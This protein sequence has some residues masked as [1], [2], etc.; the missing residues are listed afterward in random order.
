[1]VRSICSRNTD[2][3]LMQQQPLSDV[4]AA[5]PKGSANGITKHLNRIQ[6]PR[7]QSSAARASPNPHKAAS[8]QRQALS[9]KASVLVAAPQ[10][11]G[12]FGSQDVNPSNYRPNVDESGTQI[13][14]MSHTAVFTTTKIP[15]KQSPHR[16]TAGDSPEK[17]FQTAREEQT[18][19][20][21][22]DEAALYEE[23]AQTASQTDPTRQPWTSTE[24]NHAE[25][26]DG[27][28]EDTH[29]DDD[30]AIQEELNEIRSPSDESSPIRPM[31]RKNSLNFPSLPA[32]EPLTAG[33]SI[34]ARTSRTSHLDHNRTSYYN[35]PTG[36][37]SLGNHA[38]Q[39]VADDDDQDAM[40]V[41]ADQQTQASSRAES[42]AMNH[43]RTYT[44]RLQDQI[45]LLGKS[46][47]N[48][49]HQSKSIPNNPVPQ[50]T[51]APHVI[52]PEPKSPSPISKEVTQS[53]PGA[54]PEDDDDDWIQPPGTKVTE[55]ETSD[56]RPTLSK[57]HSADVMEGIRDKATVSQEDFAIQEMGI[58]GHQP[59]SAQAPPSHVIGHG[60]SAAVSTAAAMT[61]PIYDAEGPAL[62]KATTMPNPTTTSVPAAEY[63]DSPPKSPSRGFRDSP[64]KQVKNK[65]SSILK[66]SR[67]LLA[68][69]AAISA[70]GKS[71]ILSPYTLRLGYH[72]APSMDSIVSKLN[73]DGR[74]QGGQDLSPGR[75]VARRTRASVEREKEEKRREK[76]EKHVAEQMG[77]LEKAREKEREKARVFS[78][79]QERTAVMEKQVVSQKDNERF[80]PK[81]TPK[82]TRS[83]PRKAKAPE[84]IA[85]MA[86]E[87]DTEMLDVP[88]TMPPPSVPRSTGP[89]QGPRGKDI[90][91]PIKPPTQIKAKQA[92]TV[93]KVNT[94]SQHSQYHATNAAP[95]IPHDI[96]ASSSS[97]IQHQLAT[98]ASKASLQPKSS[99]QSLKSSASSTGRTKALDL[100]AKKKEQDEKEMQRRRDAKAEMERKRVAAQEEQRK[101]E[102]Q[103][104]QEADR[105]K[106]KEREQA[107]TAQTDAKKNAQRQ[108]AIEKAKQTRAPPPAVRSQPN[109]PPDYNLDED[110]NPSAASTQKTEAASCRPPSRM[111]S[112]M[113]RSQDDTS[114]P[115][116]TVLSN[117]TKAV[118]RTLAADDVEDG[119]SKRPPSRGGLS[120]QTKDA[121]RR[122]TSETTCAEQDG[123]QT[124][125]IKGAPVRPS[126]GLKKV[127]GADISSLERESADM[128][129][130][131]PKK[132]IFQNGYTNAPPS[133]TRDLFKATVTAQHAGQAK[134]GHP[135][136]M[137]QISK[138]AIPFAPSANLTSAKTPARPA[139]FNAGKSAAK[140]AQRS[141]PRFQ[142]GESIELPEI[143]TD[144][145]DEDEDDAHGMNIAAWADSPDLRRAL[146]R[147]ETMDPSQIFGPPS[148]LNMEEVFSKNKDRWHKFRARTSSANWSG[149]D[150]LTED[151]VRKDMAARDKLR[152][153]G[154]WSYD[155][156]KELL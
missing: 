141:S 111:N 137:A 7:N 50:A 104:R 127:H 31:V 48:A 75:P 23:R 90:K 110:K 123:N 138:G 136:D 86:S 140:S 117:A 114:R 145:E 62:T 9:P 154:G 126:G 11:S 132:S 57:S 27:Q 1:M 76:E 44:Q 155:M 66:S 40:D 106:Q 88:L 36:G 53:T 156:G 129:Q 51:T 74:A 80:I 33:K 60:Q 103:R 41:D 105:Q 151:D 122:R 52:R 59:E 38:W 55:G 91:R 130:D 98:K 34:G 13:T 72:A 133:V 116:N 124:S 142:N 49:N 102:Q 70:E 16:V 149:V 112:G 4:F 30:S 81:E 29:K 58:T 32:R 119:Q 131:L 69:S 139:A 84:S 6:S 120:Y 73:F 79:E 37:K 150:R 89:S 121:K 2:S 21:I 93:I 100:A 87:Q 101:Q 134:P 26:E 78:K 92:P 113:P 67:G 22:N 97:Q 115:V 14:D 107:A 61:V 3:I 108:A 94:G 64:L 39:D 135:L 118:K 144:D 17:T 82:P 18:T 99:M 12:Y 83:S 147:Q 42:V 85:P 43:T 35:R 77:K 125:S 56:T 71:S 68:S 152:R 24:Q 153:E 54:F 25:A 5:T 19:R 109:G 10:D 146:M 95:A 20:V 65:L 143:Q 63:A 148:N 47:P 8:P 15:L 46:Q 128:D 96:G 28:A 45:N